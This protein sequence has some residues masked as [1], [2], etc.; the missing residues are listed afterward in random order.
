[1][2]C[3]VTLYNLDFYYFALSTERTW[4]DYISLLIIPCIIYYVTNKETLTL[5]THMPRDTIVSIMVKSEIWTHSQCFCIC[6]LTFTSFTFSALLVKNMPTQHNSLIRLVLTEIHD[7][8]YTLKWKMIFHLTVTCEGMSNIT[9]ASTFFSLRDSLRLY[10]RL[11]E[12][13]CPS[14]LPHQDVHEF[15]FPIMQLFC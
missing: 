5:I 9:P 6:L 2:L 13:K 14:V 12:L 4:F 3:C 8:K 10:N 15:V 7:M 1:M 11:K